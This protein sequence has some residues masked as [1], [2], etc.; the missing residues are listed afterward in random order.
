MLRTP[1]HQ[2]T[3]G[4]GPVTVFSTLLSRLER[5]REDREAKRRKA[6][7]LAEAIQHVVQLSAPAVC[8]M[9]DCRR[10]L[11]I[12][13][14]NALGYLQQAI[15]RIPGPRPFSPAYWDQ[16]P[17]LQALF[18]D[19]EE[20]QAL[21]TKNRR[22]K[23]FFTQMQTNQ[24]HALLTAI[25]KERTIFG[26]A[27]EG[28]IVRRDVPQTAV[29][30]HDH[31]IID[32]SATAEETRRAL[33]DRALDTLVSQ[34]LEPVLQLRSRLDELKEHQRI[35][36]IQLKIQQTRMQGLDV[37]NPETAPTEPAAPSVH[38]VLSGLDRQIREL[39]AESDS[40]E[41]YLRQLKAVLNAPQQ[42]LTVTP[43]G[44]RLNWM[45]VKQ[46]GA[47]GDG[48]RDIR[49]AEVEFQNHLKRVAVF[50]RI[51]RRDCVKA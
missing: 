22:L 32:P 48:E 50:V 28:A 46:D 21:L 3:A 2:A 38:P 47:S 5:A 39:A 15:G 27:V 26:T 23:S 6:A 12:P 51:A 49:L 16:D 10:Q 45:G 31:R 4:R 35:L 9:R 20:M 40:S 34:I 25:K 24:A 7:T 33:I 13:V 11:R 14:E 19:A 1:S 37:L 43:I 36:A 29:E 18:V 44:M 17:L 30:F 8:T 41:E 42:A